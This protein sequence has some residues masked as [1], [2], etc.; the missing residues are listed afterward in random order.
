MAIISLIAVMI[1]TLTGTRGNGNTA[2]VGNRTPSAVS[3]DGGAL[4]F[5]NTN[6]KVTL[7]VYS[8]PMC[9]Y[10]G[11]FERANGGDD[12]VKAVQAGRIQLQLHPLA[13]LDQM[14]R[15]GTQY[16]TRASNALVAVS[17]AT[18]RP[19]CASTRACTPPAP[20][21]RRTAPASPTISSPIWPARPAPTRMS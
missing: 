4:V 3:N 17:D 20:S 14:S 2:T 1:F 9:P 16:S 12:I 6:A 8:D 15:G 13:F 10:C 11:Q 19:A 7:T 5:G 18:P 21:P